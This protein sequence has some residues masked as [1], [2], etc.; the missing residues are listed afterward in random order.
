MQPVSHRPKHLDRPLKVQMSQTPFPHLFAPLSL[1]SLTLKNRILMGSMHT[2]LED[3][4]GGFERLAAFYA[5]RTRGGV[6]LIVTGGF[7][8]NAQA[9]GLT[10]H[11]AHS[12]L[13]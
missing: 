1:G 10:E 11:A 7:G 5:E 2:G 3:M 6:S 9:L 12:T 8:V 4:A 13:C